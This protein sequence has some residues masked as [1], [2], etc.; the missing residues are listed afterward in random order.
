[1]KKFQKTLA[2]SKK[3]RYIRRDKQ[4][5]LHPKGHFYDEK[6][7]HITNDSFRYFFCRPR[8]NRRL[9]PVGS[10]NV[11]G[12]SK[13]TIPSGAFRIIANQ[14]I[15]TNEAGVTIGE[16]FGDTLPENSEIYAWD[17]SYTTYTYFGAGLGWFDAD[18]NDANNVIIDRGDAIW[19]KNGGAS[20]TNSLLSG[21][22]PES[23]ATTNALISGFNLVANPYPVNTKLQDLDIDPLENDEVYL[24]D[25]SYKVYTYFG[26]GLGWFDENL[27]DSNSVEIPSGVGLWYKTTSPRN[28][29]VAMPYSL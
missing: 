24:F 2:I 8:P 16:A 4:K 7:K 15:T 1:M 13:Q 27:N 14:L 20:S 11:M 18:L 25:G 10:A 22:V 12:Y 3:L 17:G 23:G 21:N 29:V 26:T 6:D 9:R 5:F 19:V 28:W